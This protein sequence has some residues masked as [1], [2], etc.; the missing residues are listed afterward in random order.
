MRLLLDTNIFLEVLLTQAKSEE[1]QTFLKQIDRHEVFL[2][3]FSVHSIG[4][5][6][7]RRKRHHV[8]HSFL[9][10][11]LSNGE[12]DILTLL[13]VNMEAIGQNAAKFNLDFDD[14][15]QYAVAEQHDLTLVSF[16][17]DFDRTERGRK[18]PAEVS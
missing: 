1:A 17:R 16:D 14:A 11:V 2:S 4:V 5:I 6:L 13:P 3:I 9:K 12:I 18:S 8:F 7:F 15:Y 10:D